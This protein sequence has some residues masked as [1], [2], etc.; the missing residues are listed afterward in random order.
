MSGANKLLISTL[1]PTYCRSALLQRAIASAV[2]QQG[3]DTRVC[4]FD[5]C[6]DDNTQEVVKR[7]AQC[8]TRIQYRRHSHNIGGF[9]NFDLAMRGVATPF[10][11]ILSDDDYLLPGFYQRALADLAENPE[12]MFWVGESLWVDE[13]G[14]IWDARV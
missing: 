12:A 13:Q 5:N 6:S 9:A 10:F 3:V 14:T 11:S 2:G 7:M 4:V 8:D 1:I